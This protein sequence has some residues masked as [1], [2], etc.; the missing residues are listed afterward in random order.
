MHKRVSIYSIMLISLLVFPTSMYAHDL[1]THM[2]IASKTFD[3]WQA[4][5]RGC[6]GMVEL[7]CIKISVRRDSSYFNLPGN[8]SQDNLSDTI[9]VPY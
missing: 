9:S 4:R 8:T 3:I 2:Y 6:H 5:E 7:V 1:A